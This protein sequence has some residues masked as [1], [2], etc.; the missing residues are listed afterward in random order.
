MAATP[1]QDPSTT[2]TSDYLAAFTHEVCTGNISLSRKPCR[3]GN[4][5]TAL[6]AIGQTITLLRPNHHD[7][8]L[9]PNGKL[10]FALICQLQSNKKEDPPPTCVKPLPVEFIKVVVQACC[11]SSTAKD[12]CIADMITIG[13][14]FLC[15]P[16]E[17][18]VDFDNNPFKLSNVQLYKDN[19]PLP[20]LPSK[21]LHTEDF[22]TLT[23]DTQ[24]NGVK[25][26]HFGHR[27]STSATLCPTLA[28][29]HRVTHLNLHKAI[30]HQPL[31][32][33]YHTASSSYHYLASQ[34]I[35]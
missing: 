20:I 26:E 32:S 9:Q 7:P 8:R 5:E 6:N 28:V 29:A 30:L 16:G 25:G 14:L 4:V 23:F 27:H 18:T 1:I 3:L 19:K 21:L 11:A 12:T 2:H 15:C 31:C 10:I 33:Y 34:D 22:L 13:F 17:L 35:M 24:K